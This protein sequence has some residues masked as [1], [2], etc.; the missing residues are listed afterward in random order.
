MKN[1]TARM[2]MLA[3]VSALATSAMANLTS[4][5][6]N[7]EG[8]GIGDPAALASDGWKVFAN[9][10]DPTHTTYLYGYGTFHAPNGGGGF[11]A[12]ATGEQGATQGAQYLNVYSDYNNGDHG[13]GNIIEANVFQEQTVG[14]ADLGKTFN[15]TFD[16]K[17]SSLF[18]PDGATTTAAFIK[19]LD[20]TAGYSTVAYVPLDT[21]LAS[22]TTWSNGNTLG[23]TIGNGWAGD[24]LQFGFVSNATHYQ[25]SGVY[26]DNISFAAV[27]E[28]ATLL[29]LGA[30][31]AAFA[32]KRRR[33]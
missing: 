4:Y 29:I 30:G 11:S 13:V 18:G 19:V 5:S 27:P 15:F 10:W 1:L 32:R 9:V 23:I 21:T 17:A 2:T 14:A 31:V 12:I 25:N 26:Y 20:P 7:F 24:I 16:D 3:L 22:R 8:L 33:S 6:Q 28:P